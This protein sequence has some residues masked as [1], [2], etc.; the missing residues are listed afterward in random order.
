[1]QRKNVLVANV[2]ANTPLNI[3]FRRVLTDNK[4]N[5][6]LHLCHRLMMVQLSDNPDK[7]IWK[8]VYTRAFTVKSMYLELMNGHTRVLYGN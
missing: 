1:M 8:L 2:L 7:F 4:W 3:A 6:W 5:D